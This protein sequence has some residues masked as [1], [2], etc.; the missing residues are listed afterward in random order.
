MRTLTY[1]GA[2]RAGGPPEARATAGARIMAGMLAGAV[3]AS[4]NSCTKS[5]DASSNRK[6][7]SIRCY[8]KLPT[9]TSAAVHGRQRTNIRDASSRIPLQQHHGRF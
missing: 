3:A 5:E 9:E 8:T 7:N 4:R 2:A 1:E 6:I